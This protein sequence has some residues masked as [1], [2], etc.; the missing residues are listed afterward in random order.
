MLQIHTSSQCATGMVHMYPF[1][2]HRDGLFAMLAA[3]RGEPSVQQ[4]L[5]DTSKSDVQHVTDWQ[6]VVRYLDSLTLIRLETHWPL[7]SYA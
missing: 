2:L 7:R 6:H 3:Q 5:S 4:L 1:L